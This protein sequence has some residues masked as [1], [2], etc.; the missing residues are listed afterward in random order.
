MSVWEGGGALFHRTLR[1]L[2]FCVH[3]IIALIKKHR[4]L[5]VGRSATYKFKKSSV[6]IETFGMF[7]T[8]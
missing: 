2:T 1:L 6:Q 8:E 7:Y 5:P 4:T 3:Y